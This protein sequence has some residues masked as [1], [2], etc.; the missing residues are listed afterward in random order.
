[1]NRIFADTFYWVAL[2]NR[3]ANQAVLEFSRSLT[4]SV[5]FTTDE[6]LI[7]FLTFGSSDPGLRV[8]AAF[9]VRD[10]L[11]GDNVR[12]IPQ[13]RNSF[14]GG[15]ALYQTRPDKGY[16]LTGCISMQTM[17][18][19]ASRGSHQRSAFRAGRIS[20]SVSRLAS[21]RFSRRFTIGVYGSQRGASA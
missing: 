4:T 2:T 5:I 10:I 19:G 3:S 21:Q 8:G 14:L 12:V 15:L 11:S 13:S 9:A 1:M 18:G 16:S 6:V 20:R 7:E 17:P